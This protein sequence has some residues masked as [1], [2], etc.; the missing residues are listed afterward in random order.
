MTRRRMLEGL[1]VFIAMM[2][3]T[4]FGGWWIVPIVALIAG[5]AAIAPG[6]VATTAALA[7]ALLLVADAVQGPLGR[8][9]SMLGGVMGLPGVV[10][11]VLTIL[12]P[13]LLGW[14]AATL[15]TLMSSAQP[16][17]DTIHHPD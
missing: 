3:G 15:G 2:A 6:F 9:M 8:V 16:R 5:A 10:V 13:A 17:P 1:V 12:F 11:V 7:W 14:S 4:W